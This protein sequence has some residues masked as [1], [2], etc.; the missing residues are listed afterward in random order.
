MQ[1][2]VAVR[3]IQGLSPPPHFGI[4]RPTRL[5]ERAHISDRVEDSVTTPGPTPDQYRLIEVF[6]ARGADC[7]QWQVV[8]VVPST[9]DAEV[10]FRTRLASIAVFGLGQRRSRELWR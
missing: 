10:S 8:G 3:Q 9:L 1:R 2:H 5:D 7:N 4:Q 6:G